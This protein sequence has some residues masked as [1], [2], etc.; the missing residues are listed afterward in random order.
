MQEFNQKAEKRLQIIRDLLRDEG[1]VDIAQLCGDLKVSEATIRRDLQYLE[2]IGEC[3]RKRGGAI[4]LFKNSRLEIPY[5]EKINT[6]RDMKRAIAEEAFDLIQ[7]NDSILLDS[8]STTFALSQLLPQKERLMVVTNDLLIATYLAKFPH[9]LTYMLGGN[10]TNQVYSVVSD[11]SEKFLRTCHFD[12]VFLGADAIH[13]D[14]TIFN[15]NMQEVPLK[16]AMINAG[17]QVILLVDS[18]KFKRVGFMK[19]CSVS[20]IDIVITDTNIKQSSVV[21]L[22]SNNVNLITTGKRIL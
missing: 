19:V 1:Y 10:V 9:I 11:L 12:R 14:G 18:S 22:E 15:T 17:R 13:P 21:M 3:T 20:E 7:D 4:P 8:G 2:K 16:Q 6:N 5:D